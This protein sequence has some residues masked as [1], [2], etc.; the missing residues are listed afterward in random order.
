MKLAAPA[1]ACRAALIVDP[2][3]RDRERLANEFSKLDVA[4]TTADRPGELPPSPATSPDLVVI[5]PDPTD[6]RSLLERMTLRFPGARLVIV[7][8]YPSYQASFQAGRAGASAYLPKPIAA[9]EVLLALSASAE[10]LPVPSVP[11]LERQRRDYIDWVLTLHAGNKTRA[12]KVLGIPRYSLQRILARTP[13]T[14]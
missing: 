13:P 9:R 2:N 11:S 4:V 7:T 12:A 8:A 10:V 3:Q 6:Q 14:R 1:A 5:D